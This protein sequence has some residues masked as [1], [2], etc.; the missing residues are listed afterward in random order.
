ITSVFTCIEAARFGDA[1]RHL[2][3][4]VR[5]GTALPLHL[6]RCVVWRVQALRAQM[7]GQME[8]AE[9]LATEALAI[10]NSC[11]QSDALALYAIQAGVVRMIQGRADE[12]APWIPPVE[13][14][15]EHPAQRA[16]CAGP[17]LFIGRVAD[18]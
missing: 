8:R 13:A 10:G 4:L 17:C 15:I 18:A 3:G 14:I 12:I 7:S 9:Q 1:D 2:G 5:Y 11:G 16:A 6:I